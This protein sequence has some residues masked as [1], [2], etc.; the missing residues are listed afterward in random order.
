MDSG[1]VFSPA[2]RVVTDAIAAVNG[3]SLEFYNAGTT[4]PKTVYSDSSLSTSLGSTVYLDSGGHPVSAQGGSTK[5]MVYTGSALVKI[6]V[7]TSA[8]VTLATYDNVKCTEDTSSFT[9]SGGSGIEGVLSKTANY[10]VLAADDGYWLDCD[11]TGAEF[12]ITLPSAVTVGDGFAIGIRHSG[13]TTT[14]VVKVTSVSSQ[15]IGMDGQAP[16]AFGLT[17]GGEAIWLVSNGANWRVISHAPPRIMGNVAVI[18]VADRLTAPPS[19]PTAGARYI[20]N[21]TPTGTWSSYAQH[22]VVRADGQGGWTKM[23]PPTDCGWLAYVEDE[24]LYTGFIGSAWTDLSNVTAPTASIL[25]YGVWQD[26]K[27]DG[28]VG[29]TAS[30]AAWT[31]ATINTEVYNTITGA[32]LASNKVALPAGTYLVS[33][34][35]TQQDTGLGAVRL[36]LETTG[37]IYRTPNYNVDSASNSVAVNSTY[38]V[39]L[40][41][42]ENLIVEYYAS[43]NGGT[44]DLGPALTISGGSEYEVY[45]VLTVVSL[46][47]QQGP[48]G[49]QGTQGNPGNDGG[50]G[51]WNWEI[52]TSS[53]PSTG[54]IRFN[55]GTFSS[56]TSIYLSETDANSR[57]LSALIATWDDSTSTIKGYIRCH[58]N[59]TPTNFWYG[60]IS[61]LTDNGSDVTLTVSHLSSSGSFS[62]GDDVIVELVPKGDKGD[63]G[64]AGTTVPD[65][66][67]LTEDT[68]N[69]DETDWLIEYDTSASAHKKLKPKNLGFTQAGTGAV[70]R[71]LQGKIREII[72]PEDFGA[73]GNFN[74]LTYTGTDDATAF[75]TMLTYARTL[76]VN[77]YFGNSEFSTIAIRLRPG[78]IYR[79]GSSLNLTGFRAGLLI[80]GNS[81]TLYSI[82]IN[83]KP[84][85]D[86]VYTNRLV[87][88]DL[89]VYA[90][91]GSYSGSG[92]QPSY[93]LVVGRKATEDASEHFFSNLNIK[94]WYNKSSYYNIGSELVTALKCEFFNSVATTTASTGNA[95]HLSHDNEASFTS[96]FQTV[97]G[98]WIYGQNENQFLQCNVNSSQGRGMRIAGI[99]SNLKF[100]NC[101]CAMSSAFPAVQIAGDHYALTLDIH[102]E[103]ASA[104]AN[105]EFDR[106][107]NVN[108]YGLVMRDMQTQA[109][110]IM[111]STAG[112]GTLTIYDGDL[113]FPSANST[114]T[115]V[116]ATSSGINFFG[117]LNLGS[118]AAGLNNLSG[119][120]SFRGEI[121]TPAS[122][123]TIR[124]NFPGSGNA[125]IYSAASDTVTYASV[126]GALEVFSN[127]ELG[128]LTDTT[129]ARASAGRISVE[130]SNVLMASDIGV[131]VQGLDS[132]LTAV[133]GLSSNGL[134]ARTGTGTAAVRTLTAPAAGITVSNGDGVSGNPTL[135]LANDL[136]ALEALSGTNTIYYRSASD[137]WTAVTINANLG[138]SAGT[139]G[140]ALGTAATKATGTS[141]NTVPLLDGANTW[142]GGNRFNTANVKLG[143]VSGT[144]AGFWM[145]STTASDRLFFGQDATIDDYFRI[146]SALAG[147]NILAVAANATAG[148]SSL[149]FVGQMTLGSPT[150][151]FK[152][153]GTLN[154]VG[155]YDD[156]TLLTCYVFDQAVDGSIDVAKWDALVPD[157]IHEERDIDGLKKP[158]RVEARAH[159][160]LR[161]FKSKLGTDY[162]PT[163][164]ESYV[165]HWKEKKH[166]TSM[167][168]EKKFDPKQGMSTGAW[169]QRLLETVELQALH[170]EQLL[171]RINALEGGATVAPPAD[172]RSKI[173]AALSGITPEATLPQIATALVALKAALA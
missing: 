144:G 152:G 120:N 36:R 70:L 85:L 141:G 102:V 129:I 51:A 22:D 69:D 53:G 93:G 54:A 48:Q 67:G 106:T 167:P 2:F 98:G 71:R 169:I 127:I 76:Q 134:I 68:V 108:I 110:D 173:R 86:A 161:K 133:A 162:D 114:S 136:A 126:A 172:D 135:A 4:T 137:T 28:T 57:A 150:G 46:T 148:S 92:V 123:T 89:K 121:F 140:S 164:L 37:T 16:T 5:V 103:N 24:N 58:E 171:N 20:I 39:V 19:S 10:T 55:N 88:R 145:D 122:G 84:V 151:G 30:T 27:T 56:V 79:I 90:E 96:D 165:R 149:N 170:D 3:G 153:A 14:N 105:L 77:D 42:A 131:T 142:S 83:N 41:V 65:L 75:N 99:T 31:T 18:T 95:I 72:S 87:I 143:H 6:I 155:V 40:P 100:D 59:A 158:D 157:R 112:A 34:S 15:A 124:T 109:V 168:N 163:R 50:A 9:S 11:P 64:T 12:T 94:G 21:G 166:L 47:A 113:H 130:G 118:T 82:D 44:S 81:A 156:N 97:A 139:L 45:R 117:R 146:Y 116:F 29:G 91:N 1:F 138:F 23:T 52:S 35:H 66:S 17:G 125:V 32:S 119:A 104:T 63:T 107:S 26:R 73:V 38:I 60:T 159:E 43:S 8:G 147:T 115:K 78:A 74:P 80:E 128:H 154:A 111:K 61:A 49:V 62:A 160:P 101:F 13:T 7:K 33:V 25:P 132:D